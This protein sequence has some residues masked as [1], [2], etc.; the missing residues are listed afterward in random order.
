M[1]GNTHFSDHEIQNQTSFARP[2]WWQFPASFF[3]LFTHARLNAKLL[4]TDEFAIDSLYHVHGFWDTKSNITWNTLVKNKVEV[5]IT[6][7]EGPR[8][9]LK[10]VDIS[11][12]FPE[13]NTKASGVLNKLKLNQPFDRTKLDLVSFELN[14][15]YANRGYPYAEVDTQIT[16]SEDKKIAWAGFKVWQGELVYFGKTEITGLKLTDQ[17]IVRRELAYKEGGI[18]SREKIIDSKQ[19]IY[20]TGIF[21]FVTLD[22]RD[23]Q[24]KPVK[25]DFSLRVVERKPRFVKFGFLAGQSQE[26]DLTTDL[27]GEY[28]FRNLFGTGRRLSFT[29]NSSFALL[30]KT[31]YLSSRF[32]VNYSQPWLLGFRTPLDLEGYYEPGAKSVKQPYRI[33][34]FGGNLNL[35]RQ[36]KKYTRIWLSGGYQQVNVYGIEDDKEEAFRRDRGI[37]VRRKVGLSIENDTRGSIF[38]PLGGSHT[39][40]Q[41]EFYGGILGG[42]HNFSKLTLSWSRYFQPKGST[43]IE[44]WAFRLRGGRAFEYR[45]KDFVPSFDRFYLGGASTIRGYTE[46]SLGPTTIDDTTGKV[47]AIGGKIFALANMEYRSSLFGKFGW[48]IFLDWGNVWLETKEVGIKSMLLS[49][50]AGVQYFS[51]LGPLRLDYGRKLLRGSDPLQG[52]RLHLSILYAF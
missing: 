35:R 14:K 3:S 4:A 48:S 10:S 45:L 46:N 50:G 36:F 7:S 27:S 34:R 42:D 49:G 30:S 13:Y 5:L 39:Q 38:I 43:K 12:G 8:T 11:G 52:G 25:P 24:Q 16:T 22:A 21:S 2:R 29:A 32:T 41:S 47:I 20:S 37:N 51:P 26:Q 19:R 31:R 18:Y 17:K 6:I 40:F 28:G 1:V 33:E 44:A 23:P 15:I 9:Y